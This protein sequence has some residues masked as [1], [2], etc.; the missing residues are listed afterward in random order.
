MVNFT[1]ALARLKKE[2][3]YEDKLVY[4]LTTFF[5]SSLDEISDLDYKKGQIVKEKLSKIAS[6]SQRHSQMFNMLIEMVV[7]NGNNNY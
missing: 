3:D 7:K 4:D 1:D 6:D 5:I 2:K